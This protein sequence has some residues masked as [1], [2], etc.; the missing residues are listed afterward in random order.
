MKPS[1]LVTCLV[2]LAFSAPLAAAPSKDAAAV[3]AFL[4]SVYK[5]YR[6]G[7]DGPSFDKPG[8]LFEPALA[9]AVKADRD[10]AAA[11]GE[12][13]KFDADPICQCQD[14]DPFTPRIGDA[15]V[16]GARA[17]AVVRFTNLGEETR[18]TYRLV[19]VDGKW[20]IAD[21]VGADGSFR[22]RFLGGK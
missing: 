10:K 9:R 21:I 1:V 2:A 8:A 19:K 13:G 3:R 20:R 22:E 5:T 16:D 17:E 14:W 18:L 6:A 12:V 11:D 4:E 15:T 7:G